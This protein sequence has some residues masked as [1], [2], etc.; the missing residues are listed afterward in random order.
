MPACL[1][2]KQAHGIFCFLFPPYICFGLSL[3]LR[4][5]HPGY[6]AFLVDDNEKL[7]GIITLGNFI[8]NLNQVQEAVNRNFLFVKSTSADCMLSE[9]EAIYNKY[10]I[11]SD[12]PVID[13]AQNSAINLSGPYTNV[14][15]S[16]F[17]SSLLFP[18]PK[19]KMTLVFLSS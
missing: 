16:C 5:K 8:K 14:T 10:N 13:E 3:C 18:C 7:T 11:R 17:S 6:P 2:L 15:P 4:P 9:A 12:I 19:S 1:L